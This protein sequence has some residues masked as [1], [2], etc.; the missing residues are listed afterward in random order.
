MEAITNAYQG[1]AKQNYTMLDNLKLGYGGTKTEMERLLKDATKLS[2][3]K[4]DISN[5]SDVYQAIHV[6]QNELGVT[7][8]TAKEAETTILGSIS[9]LKASFDNFLNGSG[10]LGQVVENVNLVVKNILNVV[11]KLLPEIMS[12]IVQYMPEIINTVNE[13]LNTLL[14]SVFEYGPTMFSQISDILIGVVNLIVENLPEIID[15][16]LKMLISLIE[17]NN[18]S[19][20]TI[21]SNVT[22]YY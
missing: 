19:I 16:G 20:T 1:F 9:S 14:Q 3:V 11:N 5:L 8:T 21:N 18:K 17:R 6:I 12:N 10:N 7:G 2:G 4:Y 13:L 15:C 22:N